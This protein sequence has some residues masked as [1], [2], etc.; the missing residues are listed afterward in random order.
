TDPL[1]V[2]KRERPSNQL[3]SLTEYDNTV[4]KYLEQAL[5]PLDK[6]IQLNKSIFKKSN[7]IYIEVNQDNELSSNNQVH[8]KGAVN[9]YKCRVCSRFGHNA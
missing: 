4:S 2:Q 6:N 3:K 1:V 8:E 7:N 5:A 9:K